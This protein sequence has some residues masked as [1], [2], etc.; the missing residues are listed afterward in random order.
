MDKSSRRLELPQAWQKKYYDRG[1]WRVSRNLKFFDYIYLNG[2]VSVKKDKNGKDNLG[3]YAVLTNDGHTV[4]VHGYVRPKL[5]TMKYVRKI[6]DPTM[7]V[8]H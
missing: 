6:L 1:V 5:S 3:T 4:V 8:C 7:G 2:D